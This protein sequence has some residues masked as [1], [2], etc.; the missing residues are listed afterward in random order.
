M[1]PPAILFDFDGVLADSE[2]LHLQ[3]YQEV[4]A[5]EGITLTRPEYYERY[6][7][8][9]D[10]GV[11]SVLIPKEDLRN[12]NFENCEFSWAQT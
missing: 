3:A 8:F 2:S 7:G 9:N 4:L 12:R 10:E 5:P 11:F 6:L 1:A